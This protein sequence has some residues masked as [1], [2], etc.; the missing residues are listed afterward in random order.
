MKAKKIA[1]LC[2]TALLLTADGAQAEEPDCGTA[3]AYGEKKFNETPGGGPWERGWQITVSD[4]SSF[5]VPVYTGIEKNKTASGT[6]AGVLSI[7]YENGLLKLNFAMLDGYAMNETSFYLSDKKA[8]TTAHGQYSK[9]NHADLN[10]ST[11]DSYELDV[12][13]YAG[14]TLYLAAAQAAVCAGKTLPPDENCADRPLS[15]QGAW[16]ETQ[17][18]AAGSVVQRGGSS[19]VNT[20]CE[21]IEGVEPAFDPAPVGCWDLLAAKGE[22]GDI[23]ETGPAGPQGV[24]GEIGPT[25]PAGPQGLKGDTGEKGDVGPIGPVGPQGIQG[26]KGDTGDKGDKG[27]TGAA[28]PQGIQG[29]TG[30]TGPAGPQGDTGAAGA[31]GPAGPAG[32]Q[33]PTGETGAVG[34][35]GIQGEVGPQGPQGEKGD[36]GPA[37]QQGP[38]G[39]Q[40]AA[41][42]A[43]PAGP[44]GP[45][46]PEGQQ[47][48]TGP[49]GPQGPQGPAGICECPSTS[50]DL[51][52][53]AS[54]STAESAAVPATQC[55]EGDFMVGIDENGWIICRDAGGSCRT[56]FAYGQTELDDMLPMTLWGW[57]L[58]LNQGQTV[59][60]PLYT[61][62]AG[63]DLSK[64]VRVGEL[65]AAY[66]SEKVAVTFKMTAEAAM[67]ATY[68]HVGESNVGAALPSEYGNAHE[69]L[70]NALVDSY[71]V[72]VSGAGASLRIVASAVVCNK[73]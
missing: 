39:D 16:Q 63:N 33:G 45:R 2:L 53:L 70:N 8:P 66:L 38:K 50:S 28:G 57:Q 72:K 60:Q 27:D 17:I 55:Y 13:V 18:Y 47:G 15:W 14:E 29:E 65:T 34:P 43:G 6:V 32:P 19:Y 7:S 24:Q 49:V 67:S 54:Q 1:A 51:V 22:K 12:S 59:T 31:V 26:V 41:G 20:C 42:P 46:G 10:G 25:G 37:G 62:A 11:A 64:A 71:E 23:G 40:G 48:Q 35:Q 30:P 68:L 21:S 58:T 36:T 52:M 73:K 4:G 69:G 44:Q 9:Y 5:V 3:Y 61:G 56:A